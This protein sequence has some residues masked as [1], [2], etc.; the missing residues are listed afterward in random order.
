MSVLS[1]NSPR[2]YGA[3]SAP[4]RY[5]MKILFN[6]K[7][8]AWGILWWLNAVLYLFMV[9]YY[10]GEGQLSSLTITENTQSSPLSGA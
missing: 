7:E 1:T 4:M 9:D 3:A 10:G 2:F 6:I 5:I 8:Y